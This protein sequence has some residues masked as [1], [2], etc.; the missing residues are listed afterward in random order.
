MMSFGVGGSH[1]PTTGTSEIRPENREI[2]FEIRIAAPPPPEN[3]ILSHF[4]AIYENFPP[5]MG[6]KML[7]NGGKMAP[8]GGAL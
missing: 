4:A 2:R 8:N 3:P 6:G 5:E 7:Q 1:P